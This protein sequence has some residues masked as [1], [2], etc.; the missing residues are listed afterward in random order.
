[1]DSVRAQAMPTARITRPYDRLGAQAQRYRIWA[2]MHPACGPDGDDMFAEQMAMFYAKWSASPNPLGDLPLIVVMGTQ[3]TGP[4][5]G[6]SLELWRS[7]S[8][9]IDLSR[10]SSRGRLLT[11]TLSGHHV[12]LDNPR[13]VVSAIRDVLRAV[14]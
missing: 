1:M 8:L 11:D 13:A 10:L 3:G 5:P 4:P 2:L 14:P 12:H 9:R 6:L 7:D